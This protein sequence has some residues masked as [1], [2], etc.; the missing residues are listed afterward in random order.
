[1]QSRDAGIAQAPL[2]GRPQA[3][4]DVIR[5]TGDGLPLAAGTADERLKDPTSSSEQVVNNGPMDGCWAC[6]LW[7]PGV[8]VAARGR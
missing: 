5:F 1:M 8:G 3:D 6:D 4:Q 7:P 2:F